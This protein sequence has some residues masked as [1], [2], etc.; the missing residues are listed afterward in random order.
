MVFQGALGQH[1]G[2]DEP[3]ALAS[4]GSSYAHA[5]GPSPPSD[6][7][8][9]FHLVRYYDTDDDNDKALTVHSSFNFQCTSHTLSWSHP[10]NT[11]VV[12]CYRIIPPI[13]DEV[14]WRRQCGGPRPPSELVEEVRFKPGPILICSYYV[15]PVQHRQGNRNKGQ[16]DAGPVSRRNTQAGLRQHLTN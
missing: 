6:T 14:G 1:D 15:T 2:L 11:P 9:C 5:M 12:K 16:S 8:R 4:H 10:Y 13:A 3:L 7:Y